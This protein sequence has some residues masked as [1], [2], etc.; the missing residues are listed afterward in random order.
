VGDGATRLLVDVTAKGEAKTTVAV[1]HERLPD[2]AAVARAKEAWRAR[3][4]ALKELLER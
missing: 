4:A 3:P 2:A 1:Q